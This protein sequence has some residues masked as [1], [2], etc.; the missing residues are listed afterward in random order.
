M[1]VNPKDVFA[2]LKEIRPSIKDP[3]TNEQGQECIRLKDF[4][5]AACGVE[6]TT[7]RR[8]VDAL[9]RD[10]PDLYNQ[11]VVKTYNKNGGNETLNITLEGGMMLLLQ[12]M[13]K[14]FWSHAFQEVIATIQQVN[15]EEEDVDMQIVP[16]PPPPP[17]DQ[18]QVVVTDMQ[19]DDAPAPA[20]FHNQRG[21]VKPED[22]L[23]ELQRLRPG[24]MVP[25]HNEQ[26]L[27]CVKLKDFYMAVSGISENASKARVSD[28]LKYYPDLYQQVVSYARIERSKFFCA[29]LTPPGKVE[30]LYLSWQPTL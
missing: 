3:F 21:P 6:D 13:P 5:M 22:V 25:F 23:A 24:V 15:E 19:I 30:K 29:F 10:H 28:L 17:L 1:Q 16:A 18:Q 26:G 20:P 27:L 12:Q 14:N 8:R 7:A 11:I 9:L 2:K 4:Y